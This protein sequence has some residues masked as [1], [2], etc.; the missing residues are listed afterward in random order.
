MQHDSVSLTKAVPAD[1][2]VD[3]C[4]SAV[5]PASNFRMAFLYSGMFQ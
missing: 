1:T 4:T 3:H 5:L 2:S